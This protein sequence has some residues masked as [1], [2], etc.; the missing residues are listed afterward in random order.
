MSQQPQDPAGALPQPQRSPNQLLTIPGFINAGGGGGDDLLGGPQTPWWRRRWV[1][2]LVIILLLAIVGILI[3]RAFGG[4]P[5]A[6]YN[7]APVTRGN[8][9]STIS[10]T[11]PVQSAASYNLA[12]IG[13]TNATIQEIDV[14][15]GQAVKK[16]QVLAQLDKTALQNSLDKANTTLTG[17]EMTLSSALRSAGLTA[18]TNSSSINGAN[19]TLNNDTNTQNNGANS[20]ALTLS[21]DQTKLDQANKALNDAQSLADSQKNQA[22]I[23]RD[24]AIKTCQQNGGGSA[25]ISSGTPLGS[26]YSLAS[27][28]AS[29]S[30]SASA[31]AVPPTAVPPTQAPPTAVPPTQVTPT[32]APPT[33][34]PTTPALNES[35]CEQQANNAYNIAV[36]NANASVT[37]AQNNVTTAQQAIDTAQVSA[38]T[39]ADQNSGSTT[40]QRNQLTATANSNNTSSENADHTVTL[41]ENNVRMDQLNVSN[42]QFN[43]DQATLKAPHDGVVTAING[44]VGG[45]PG[46]SGN[47]GNSTSSN[48]SSSSGSSNSTFIQLVD[49]STFQVLASVNEADT[50]NLQVGQPASFTVNAFPNQT[51]NGTVS[52]ISPAGQTSSN[53]VTYPVNIDVD[54]TTLK[55]S[56]LLPNMTATVTITVL[57]RTN[58]LLIP[59]NAVNFARNASANNVTTGAAALITRQQANDATA[60]ARQQLN[61]MEADNPNLVSENPLAA[62]VLERPGGASG[63]FVAKP[64]VLG[65]SDGQSSEVL[66]GLNE[67]EEIILGTSTGNALGLP[68]T[69]GG[70][71]GGNGGGNGGG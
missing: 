55:G 66:E 12:Y 42:A 3:A 36:S 59:V 63:A 23:T 29:L 21:Q 33:P 50:A 34:T 16:G 46:A 28:L 26:L 51:F 8:L 30:N 68:T 61:S 60:Q 6:T 14:K 31:T 43:L 11:G 47:G 13:S 19:I 64:V 24:G 49:I 38:T 35:Q 25:L 32:K 17:D 22:A 4:K 69:T 58:V 5:P 45:L 9:A 7:T 18:A 27:A 65:L 54:M 52:S 56:R 40:L 67:G 15:I 53:V 10:A 20:S 39:T 70:G 1:I 48:S 37:T 71:G 44:A 57:Q 2:A 62:Y 41:D